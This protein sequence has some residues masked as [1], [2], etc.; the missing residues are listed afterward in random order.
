VLPD[1]AVLQQGDSWFLTAADARL[2]VT[3]F[4]PSGAARV[5]LLGLMT[6]LLVDDPR[7]SAVAN[8][9]ATRTE[10]GPAW[11]LVTF[12]PNMLFRGAAPPI[13]PRYADRP[14]GMAVTALDPYADWL[15]GGVDPDVPP[16]VTD[17]R[18]C[19]A[20][21]LLEEFLAELDAARPS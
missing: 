11:E 8:L 7:D 12:S 4:K 20:A 17:R 3:L 13:G 16:A 21:A 6:V 14:A 19:D 18:L 1:A 15:L 5:L 2:A 10:T 9:W